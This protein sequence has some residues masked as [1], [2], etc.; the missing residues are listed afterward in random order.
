VESRRA[1][2]IFVLTYIKEIFGEDV[3]NKFKKVNLV[4]GPKAYDAVTSVYSA[5]LGSYAPNNHLKFT[6]D[7]YVAKITRDIYGR[8]SGY[9]TSTLK[10]RILE[11]QDGFSLAYKSCKYFDYLAAQQV[12]GAK[13]AALRALVPMKEHTLANL[14]GFI[15]TFDMVYGFVEMF[16]NIFES[17]V[18]DLTTSFGGEEM[19]DIEAKG[20]AFEE[21]LGAD[22]ESEGEAKLC[23]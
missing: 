19:L 11:K 10:N 12:L 3:Y 6:P 13:H 16:E 2:I 4:N 23:I 21:E 14:L 18:V 15:I 22:V 1:K 20:A 7:I 5:I 8:Y 17:V 9:E